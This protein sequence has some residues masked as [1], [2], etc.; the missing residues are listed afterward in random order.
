DSVALLR[1]L[2]AASAGAPLV[3]AHLNHQLRGADSAADED[4]VRA[5]HAALA[6][7]TPGLVFRCERLDVAALARARGGNLEALARRVRS[8]WLAGAAGDT[9]C[10]WVAPGHTADDQAETVL[11]RLRRGTG[12]RGL[13]GIAAARGLAPGVTLVRP[14]LGVRRAEVIAY[15]GAIGQPYRE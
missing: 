9:G 4:F 3:V 6:G 1:A 10:T 12:L 5:L 8:D 11:H 13:R 7:Q 15:L 2:V 14:L